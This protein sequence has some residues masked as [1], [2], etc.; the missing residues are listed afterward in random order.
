MK[1]LLVLFLLT[2]GVCVGNAEEMKFI[3]TL[4]SPVG[5]FAQLEAVHPLVYAEAPIV[6]F[7]NTRVGAGRMTVNGANA[8]VNNL[9]LQ[10][11]TTMGGNVPEYRIATSVLMYGGG[12]IKGG[13]LMANNVGFGSSSQPKSDVA[14]TLYT[15]DVML[16][17]AKTTNLTIPGKVQTINQGSG[18]TLEWSNEYPCTYAST[19]SSETTGEIESVNYG[20]W[21]VSPKLSENCDYNA[22]DAFTVT[23]DGIRNSSYLDFSDTHCTDCRVVDYYSAELLNDGTWDELPAGYSEDQRWVRVSLLDGR[24]TWRFPS[25]IAFKDWVASMLKTA[26]GSVDLGDFMTTLFRCDSRHSLPSKYQGSNYLRWMA[27]KESFQADNTSPTDWSP[28]F[29]TYYTYRCYFV[30]A[31]IECRDISWTYKSTSNSNADNSNADT[32]C[33]ENKTEFANSYLLK[34]K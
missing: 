9:V 21:E 16:Q 28:T 19:A 10:P 25:K 29:R 20:E 26:S 23:N 31:Q 33:G 13:R 3:T 4:S 17:G 11:S 6:N 14:D 2:M 32:T 8:Y 34:S 7:C 30:A 15:N 5:T 24:E 1:K 27:Y 18:K 22:Y 12:S